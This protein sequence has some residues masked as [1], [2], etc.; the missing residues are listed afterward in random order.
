M[1]PVT[2][3]VVPI[4]LAAVLVFLASSLIHMVLGWH[5]ADFTRFKDEDGV[6]EALRRFAPAPGDYL[7]PCP[8]S[9]A[10]LKD[11]AFIEK[12]TKGPVAVLTV[13]PSGPPAMGAQLGLWFGYCVVVGIFAAYIAGRALAPG[14]HYLQVFRFAGCAA[15][16]GYALALVQNSIWWGRNWG[17]TLR[18]MVDGLVYALLTAGAFGWLWPR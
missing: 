10:S 11:P 16:M 2:S 14:A 12:M 3:L 15:F 6:M 4:L 9:S 5:K 7:L 1:V 17:M 8:T 18:S 13:R